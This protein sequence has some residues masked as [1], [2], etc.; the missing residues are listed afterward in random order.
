[1]DDTD[2]I[3]VLVLERRQPP[4]GRQAF[5]KPEDLVER[6]MNV[7]VATLRDSIRRATVQIAEVVR[8]L[9]TTEGS[10]QLDEISVGLAV[11]ASGEVQFVAGIGVEVGS[12]ITLTYKVAGSGDDG[13]SRP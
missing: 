8:G 10:M 13:E 9:P 4:T 7:P 12:T 5:P 1:M 11:S 6:V 2:T 3:Q